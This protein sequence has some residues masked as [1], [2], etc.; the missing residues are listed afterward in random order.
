MKIYL[1]RNILQMTLYLL[2]LLILVLLSSEVN[3][4]P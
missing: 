4:N 1:I 2:F 3:Y